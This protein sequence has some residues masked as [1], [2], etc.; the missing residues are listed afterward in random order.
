VIASEVSFQQMLVTARN[1]HKLGVV[2]SY[3]QVEYGIK[4][5]EACWAGFVDTADNAELNFKN[6]KEVCLEF[7]YAL[8]EYLACRGESASLKVGS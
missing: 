2:N 5:L 7:A 8:Q 1:V 3:M 4:D 6:K